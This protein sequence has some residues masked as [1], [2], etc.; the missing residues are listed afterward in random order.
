[1]ALKVLRAPPDRRQA[2]EKAADWVG[3]ALEDAIHGA[4]GCAG[5][6]RA[7]E[8]WHRHAQAKGV[9][10]QP[11]LGSVRIGDAPPQKPKPA[12]RPLAGIRVLDLT[13]VLAGPTCAKSLAE[14]GADVLKIS[15]AH[16]A[17]SGLVEMDTGIGKLS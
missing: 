16:L 3:E 1:A 7:E 9:A 4:G 2:E 12:S 13:R 5:F 15:A 14:H 8:D 17:D 11:L 10:A 6:V